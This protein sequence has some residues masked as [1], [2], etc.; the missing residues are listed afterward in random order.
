MVYLLYLGYCCCFGV[1]MN[2]QYVL[3]SSFFLIL[4]SII[5]FYFCS[6]AACKLHSDKNIQINFLIFLYLTLISTLCICQ[7]IK[8]K[9]M[10]YIYFTFPCL[11]CK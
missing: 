5:I 9:D 3:V 10:E 4:V 7:G 6:H 11:F 8:D 2:C 1:A